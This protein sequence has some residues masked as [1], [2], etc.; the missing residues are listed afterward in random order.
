[1]ETENWCIEA[2]KRMK[3]ILI[4]PKL[5]KSIEN[6]LVPQTSGLQQNE[7]NKL[8]TEVRDIKTSQELEAFLMYLDETYKIQIS[9]E[10]LDI[11]E[12][13]QELKEMTKIKE[14]KIKFNYDVEMPS[15]EIKTLE[16][17][18]AIIIKNFPSIWFETK[19]CL[20]V[21]ATISLKN[22]NGC[23]SL[24]L[25]GSPAGEKTTALSFFYGQ[26]NTYLSDIFTPRAFVSHSANVKPRDLEKVDLLP[27]LKNKVL[28]TPEL[29][30]LFEAPKEQLLDNFAT[31]TRVLDGEGLNKDTGA[32][33]HR[34][35]SGDYK[36]A[37]L[38]ATTPLKFSVWQIMGKIGNRLFFL[39][40]R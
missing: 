27:K 35:Y 23:P 12:A 28:I 4:T 31:L 30:P 11:K 13:V 39:N 16:E 20:S 17:L 32:H 14:E 1:M 18:K 29:A 8:R 21:C 7:R 6:E 25:V 40:M 36:F 9:L 5:L 2:Q 22:L 3:E 34:G 19:A 38:G 10:T 26:D 37:W 15:K 33:G 24:N